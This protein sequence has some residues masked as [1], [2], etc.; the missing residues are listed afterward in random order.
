MNH[1]ELRYRVELTVL[2]RSL[3]CMDE[4]VTNPAIAAKYAETNKMSLRDTIMILNDTYEWSRE[5]IADWLDNLHESGRLDLSFAGK[6]Q[7]EVVKGTER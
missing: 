1:E 2:S 3:P 4:L 5:K 6:S 7:V